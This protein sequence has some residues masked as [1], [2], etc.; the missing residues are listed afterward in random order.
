MKTIILLGLLLILCSAQCVNRQDAINRGM[1][2]VNAH[3]PYDK[4]GK[5]KEYD[6]VCSGLVGYA[7]Q[8]PKPG[9]ASW[10]L[11]PKG[12]CKQVSKNDLVKGDLMVCPNEHVLLFDSWANSEKSS[13]NGIEESGSQGSVRRP[14]PWPYFSGYNPGCYIPCKVVKACSS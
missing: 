14:I 1:E 7:W 12:Y 3:V 8:F 2:W 5:Y 9:I 10:D 13:Y 6:M 11:I 4:T